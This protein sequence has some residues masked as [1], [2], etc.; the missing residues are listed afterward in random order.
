MKYLSLI[1]ILLFFTNCKN[2]NLTDNSFVVSKYNENYDKLI[3]E[4]I[5]KDST[6]IYNEEIEVP[7]IYFD[8]KLNLNYRIGHIHFMILD[9]TTTYYYI[10]SLENISICGTDQSIEMT[11]QDSINF[12]IENSKLLPYSKKIKTQQITKILNTYKKQINNN[13]GIPLTIS[14]ASKKDSIQG[15][16]MQNILS[17]MDQNGIKSYYIR[18]FNESEL[19]VNFK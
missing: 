19:N 8:K 2:E 16:I 11:E 14:F 17:Y 7:E 12:T 10:N 4:L 13:N 15:N 1:I 5:N 6:N 3:K 9:T 18:K